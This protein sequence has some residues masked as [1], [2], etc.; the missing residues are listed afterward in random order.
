MFDGINHQYTREQYLCQI[1]AYMFFTEE[2]QR[3]DPVVNNQ[4]HKKKVAVIQYF[5]TEIVLSLFLGI[6]ES[7]KNDW[8]SFLSVFIKPNISQKTA[9]YSETGTQS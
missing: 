5:L 8:H 9:F 4:W 3:L 6:Y 7:Y 1:D 2:G